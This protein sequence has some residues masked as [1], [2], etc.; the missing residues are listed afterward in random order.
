MKYISAHHISGR[1][2]TRLLVPILLSVWLSPLALSQFGNTGGSA[3]GGVT[4][5][6]VG[7]T[8]NVLRTEMG[9]K[10]DT[11]TVYPTNL[12][13]T[14]SYYL[15]SN[16]TADTIVAAE[17]YYSWTAWTY[18]RRTD[19][20]TTNASSTQGTYIGQLEVPLDA[21]STY[22]VEHTIWFSSNNNNGPYSLY[23][24][25]DGSVTSITGWIGPCPTSG[26]DGTDNRW[27]GTTTADADTTSPTTWHN[28]N[29]V[30][31]VGTKFRIVTDANAR[32]LNLGWRSRS[33]GAYTATV[34]QYSYVRYRKMVP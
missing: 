34:Y 1:N 5:S 10:A 14:L 2:L 7:D 13:D 33:G 4:A 26:G 16:G 30:F 27:Y 22:E 17:A 12:P 18:R 3:G 32:S 28:A 9:A 29:S 20:D 31:P 19:A 6:Q 24:D 21:S 11:S 23:P 25:L 8:A 15:R